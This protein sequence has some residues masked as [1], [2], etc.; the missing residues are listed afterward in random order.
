M[1]SFA[2][3][4][5]AGTAEKRYR[6]RTEGETQMSLEKFTIADIKNDIAEVSGLSIN[7]E[8][9]NLI[10][11]GLGSLHIM[12]L[13]NK[14]R[15]EGS[16][17]TFAKL[18]SEPFLAQWL[19]IANRMKKKA[20][21][22]GTRERKT[23]VD[24][25]E[26]Y[27]MTDVQY[28]YWIGRKK[29][30]VLGGVGCHAYLETVGKD[31]DASKLN[32]SWKKV[33]MHHPMLHTAFDDN[34]KQ[35]T[36]KNYVPEDIQINDLR[37]YR[38]EKAE[39]EFQKIR[40]RISHRIPDILHGKNA[41]VTLTIMPDEKCVMHYD[42]D[43]LSA[44]VQSF[45]RVLE[46][47]AAVY[48][49]ETLSAASAE[50]NF[51]QYLSENK[52]EDTEEYREAEKFW[53]EKI[54]SMPGKP[55]LPVKVRQEDIEEV[56]FH[57]RF[58]QLGPQQWNNFKRLAESMNLTPA[59]ALLAL[60]AVILDRWSANS[61]FTVNL[62][63]FNRNTGYAGSEEAVADFSN[64][65]LLDMDMTQQKSFV[66]YA[67]DIQRNFHSSMKHSC[68]SG[69]D[70]VRKIAA[71][72]GG[73]SCPAPV[74]FACNLGS[75]IISDKVRRCF[76]EF[77]YMLS[78]TPQVWLDFQMYDCEDGGILLKWD[79]V[80]EI[81]PEKVLDRMFESYIGY[82]KRLASDEIQWKSIPVIAE[83]DRE[84][85]ACTNG[86]LTV[87]NIPEKNLISDFLDKVQ[88]QP[89]SIAL[90]SLGEA[91]P[92]SYGQLYQTAA[93]IA[94]VLVEEG[95][96]PDD[97]VAVTLPKGRMQ[98]AAVIG[99]LLA[100]GV[101]V[102]V[103]ADQPMER[104]KKIIHKAEIK[105]IVTDKTNSEA[106]AIAD[107][108]YIEAGEAACRPGDG[109]APR[110]SDPDSVAYI[111]FTSGSTGE[112]KGVVIEHRAAYNTIADINERYGID[113][114]D[115]LLAVSAL[116]FDLSV[117][118]IFGILGAGGSIVTVAEEDR[119][120]SEKW[121]SAVRRLGITVWNSVPAIFDMLLISAQ[122]EHFHSDSLKRVFLSGDWIGLD[123]PERLK[124]VF[125]QA[126][127]TSMGGA[128]EA[129]IWSNY[130]DVTL[131]LNEEWN[132]IPYG[133]PLTNQQ[134]NVVDDKGRGCPEWVVGELVIAGKG[135]AKEYCNNVE[136]T[137]AHFY[138]DEAGKRWYRTGDLGRFRDGGIIEFLGRKDFQVKVRGHRIELGEIENAVGGFGQV[139]NSTVETYRDKNGTNHLVAFI[140][141]EGEDICIELEKEDRKADLKEYLR[142]I[143]PYY[144]IPE[145]YIFCES[146]PLTDNGKVNRKALKEF[147]IQKELDSGKTC[148]EPTNE[149][150]RKLLTIW[151]EILGV[152]EISCD[153]SFFELGG[154]SLSAVRLNNAIR[155][156]FEIEFLLKDIFDKPVLSEQAAFITGSEALSEDDM[157]CGMRHNE[158]ER[159]EP[160]PLTKVQKAYFLGEKN[161]FDYG[162]ISTHYYF[163]IE[164]DGLDTARLERAVNKVVDSNDM[165]HAVIAEDGESQR[166]LKE[167]PYYKIRQYDADNLVEKEAEQLILSV[168]DEM[169]HRLFDSTSLP[170]F[171]IRVIKLGEHYRINLCFDNIIFDGY[172]ISLFFRYVTD[173]Y[174]DEAYI[175]ESSKFTFRDYM[176]GLEALKLTEAYEKSRTY[177]H[178]RLD[179]LP[180]APELP[181]SSVVQTRGNRFEH[182]E[183][184]I[185]EAKWKKLKSQIAAIGG[186]TPTGF[187]ISLYT[188]ILNRWSKTS[189]FTLNLT[190]F[191]RIRMHEDVDKIIGDFTSLTMLE[192]DFSVHE[193]FAGRCRNL[194]EQ[195][196]RDLDHSQYDG[197]DVERQLIQ[198]Y[199]LK[200]PAFP[201]V[202][203]SALGFEPEKDGVF[204]KRLYSFSE[205][206]QVWLDH[207]VSEENG[208]LLL[209]WDF[210]REQFPEN[211]IND[212]YET[213]VRT[214]EAIL[215]DEK[216][217]HA[218]SS[219]IA[220][221]QYPEA[222]SSVNDTYQKLPEHL[223]HSKIIDV[224]H[225]TPDR[226][227]V[228]YRD[229]EYTYSD[230]VLTASAV[231]DELRRIGARQQ[232]KIAVMIPKSVYQV[233][234]VIGVLGAGCV[235]VP[236]DSDEDIER[237]KYILENAGIKTVL[238]L[239]DNAGNV[240]GY[241]VIAVDLLAKADSCTLKTEGNI[242]EI[243]YII[244]TSGST[245]VP[246]G[247][248][249]TH[250]S[251]V[252]TIEDINS[253]YEIEETDTAIGLSQLYFDL[254]VYDIFGLLS[255][256]GCLCYPNMERYMDASYW[257]ELCGKYNVTVWNS[258]PAFMKIFVDYI[259]MNGLPYPNLRIAMLS[260]D[261]I[262]VD[263]FERIR[264]LNPHT[265]CISLGGATEASIWSIYYE[266]LR[267]NPGMS[268]IPYGKALANQAF[269]VLDDCLD[270]KP[271]M[272]EGELYIGGDGLA[273]GYINNQEETD[274]RFITDEKT[275]RRL[276]RTG[277]LGRM[278]R[279]GNI[280]FL[281]RADTQIKLNGFRIELGEIDGV[282][283][284]IDGVE[285]SVTAVIS[286]QGGAKKL[287]SYVCMTDGSDIDEGGL[288]ETLKSKLPKYMIPARI[289]F[290]DSMPLTS[291]GK[292]DRKRITAILECETA[293]ENVVP[294]SFHMNETEKA[295]A[296]IMK[297]LLKVESITPDDDFYDLGADSLIMSNASARIS[298]AFDGKVP[299]DEIL[300]AMLNDSN[301]R[302]VAELVGA[303]L[304]K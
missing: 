19:V 203:T 24:R 233:Y 159:Y 171:D 115:R 280:E 297:E 285:S 56:K 197:V 67:S 249:I 62:P 90:L 11:C 88:S 81:F 257:Y 277:D 172:S 31:I 210:L 268:S 98:I 175:P 258:V 160:F 86:H 264:C 227:A 4:S 284:G 260:G 167:Y 169:A 66:E 124:A 245:G 217:W 99:V 152:S 202:F 29:N 18:I 42:I 303:Y 14:W 262:P 140:V 198:K 150:E 2:E 43:L 61:R 105:W 58:Q 64:I 139:K 243:A 44:D 253:R 196:W 224:Y 220:Q 146:I 129:S 283:T 275:G 288:K 131:P 33:V 121:L 110:L 126:E 38:K 231:A 219:S 241:K 200:G 300:T 12:R 186:I 178:E 240:T 27:D 215:D 266:Y 122:T 145:I 250:G 168:R 55:E 133:M 109:F 53:N 232:E 68:Y 35:R 13:A 134:F 193:T 164:Y 208:G 117:Y 192:T 78:Q 294:Q 261:W 267:P 26:P 52:V 113:S 279:D 189:H 252:N 158:E 223:L 274:R 104:Q 17:A 103:G 251:A 205:T 85:E 246:K 188:E 112:P 107:V 21:S 216:L 20:R 299:F 65:L 47:L 295:I 73:E 154:D 130:F 148:V 162:G 293:V 125:P 239:S 46:D 201:Y 235:Y 194:Q 236:I 50:W 272:A 191:N 93:S 60:Y 271:I 106:E 83:A 291:N 45:Q 254:S 230:V 214:I 143:L 225:R 287:Y 59:M 116:D 34:G 72:N 147:D 79:S 180:L 229:R 127:L 8:S 155:E 25:Y 190:H 36:I 37:G 87:K 142:G 206:P 207:Q 54:R 166:V 75:P 3:R 289:I 70:V 218:K 263:V 22:A 278:M 163:E 96:K 244:H 82:F 173:C 141:P 7:D 153:D 265:R 48:S 92:M 135:L 118:D 138:V 30:Q 304:Q 242:D 6:W 123:I 204:G 157:V 185:D 89:D 301:V 97:R 95:V 39:K 69:V 32:D 151:R 181:V 108:K 80:D 156:G 256:G 170:L 91:E 119:R 259:D 49:G 23:T 176:T 183:Y 222:V 63:I 28:S 41:A 5:T 9:L 120:D 16:S 111:I 71:E 211:M 234:A 40:E 237:K 302:G 226:T 247:V 184:M 296:H 228:I 290:A 174:N 1:Q 187:F 195:L 212:I 128:T 238:T 94:S 179:T 51:A 209:A 15:K 161:L 102:P 149:T 144:M 255:V 100:G 298:N 137:A 276:Y 270:I 84:N 76:G 182:L 132:S 248:I 213:Y 282:L 114:S 199:N 10:E 74:V 57:T 136:Q 177:W 292:V 286:P 269:Y 221:Y 165:L 101:Y 273:L 77:N 281:G